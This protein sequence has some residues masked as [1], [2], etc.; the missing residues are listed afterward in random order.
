[1]RPYD[2]GIVSQDEGLSRGVREALADPIV[3]ALLVADRVDLR[4]VTNSFRRIAAWLSHRDTIAMRA[5]RP[6][7]HRDAFETDA[8]QGSEHDFVWSEQGAEG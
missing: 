4:D 6:G 2:I 7:F 5:P 1:M 8:F 3:Q